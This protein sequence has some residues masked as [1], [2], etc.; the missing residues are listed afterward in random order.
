ML[1][2]VGNLRKFLCLS[3]FPL[4]KLRNYVYLYSKCVS[5]AAFYKGGYLAFYSS[6][7]I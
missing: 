3:F 4:L 6:S 5:V 2:S 1:C 7:H